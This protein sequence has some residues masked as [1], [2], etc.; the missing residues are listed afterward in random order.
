[1]RGEGQRYRKEEGEKQTLAEHGAQLGAGSHDPEIT[2]Q[3]EIKS[4]MLN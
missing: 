4:W 3:A 1:M 2:N